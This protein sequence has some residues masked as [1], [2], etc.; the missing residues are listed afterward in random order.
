MPGLIRLPN[1]ARQ[2]IGPPLPTT[3]KAAAPSPSRPTRARPRTPKRAGKSPTAGRILHPDRC[4]YRDALSRCRGRFATLP[5]L[6]GRGHAIERRPGVRK[7][8]ALGH[9]Q[10]VPPCLHPPDVKVAARGPPKS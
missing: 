9:G 5:C 1:A 8:A 10:E 2:A 7:G 3:A 4:S 6:Q